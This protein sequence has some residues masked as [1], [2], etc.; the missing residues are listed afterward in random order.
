MVS[1]IT[2]SGIIKTTNDLQVMPLYDHAYTSIFFFFFFFFG[3]GGGY[4]YVFVNGHWMCVTQSI[5]ASDILMRFGFKMKYIT[6][7]GQAM[8]VLH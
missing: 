5:D 3:G 4:I 7:Y 6:N 1:F 2:G 8:T